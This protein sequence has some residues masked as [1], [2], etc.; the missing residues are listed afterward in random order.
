MKP[1]TRVLD[2]APNPSTMEPLPTFV[3][4]EHDGK[5]LLVNQKGAGP[6]QPE[7]GR[8][9]GK[10]RLRLPTSKEAQLLNVPY[11]SKRIITIV[12][13][14]HEHH[15]NIGYP[16]IEWPSDWAWK[17]ACIADNGVDPLARE[18]IYRSLHRLVSKV[19]V[20]NHQGQVLMAR[21]E[22]GHFKGEWTLP[23]GY[24]DT[25]EHPM[26]ACMREAL[27]EVGLKVD[28][29]DEAP[30]ITQR[31]FNNEGISFVSFTYDAPW[32]GDVQ[33]LTPLEGE[34]S[35]VEMVDIDEAIQRSVSMFDREALI[36]FNQR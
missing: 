16:T 14:G 7:P 28:P 36:A 5:V 15:I 32:N 25:D 24:M 1:H 2:G 19:I 29:S 22:R 13:D 6:Q 12:L 4:L 10:T 18:C 34:I 27:E 11:R 17:D 35:D 30:V 21:V 20:H 9:S 3:Y 33:T 26:E 31:I 23:G 8:T